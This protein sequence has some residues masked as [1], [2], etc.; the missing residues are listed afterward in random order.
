MSRGAVEAA[1]P[2]QL[3]NCTRYRR[4]SISADPVIHDESCACGRVTAS[5]NGDMLSTKWRK[6]PTIYGL[7]A[8]LSQTIQRRKAAPEEAFRCQ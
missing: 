1:P 8:N 2:P 7:L 4:R 5:A 6:R 3:P